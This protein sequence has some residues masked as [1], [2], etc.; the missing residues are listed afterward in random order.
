MREVIAKRLRSLHSLY[1][2]VPALRPGT[3]GAYALALLAVG[4]ATV[5][6]L[7]LD[8]YL[9]GVQFI[10]YSPAI[11]LITLISGFGPGLFCAVLSTAA[12]DFFLLSPRWTFSVE[13][14]GTLADL[15]AFGPVAAYLVLIIG[16][17]RFA[18]E[19][20][21]IEASKD[22]LQLALDAA[23]LGWWRYDVLAQVGSG[24][25]R[26][27][28]IFDVAADVLTIEDLKKLVHPDDAERFWADREAA[29]H[30]SAPQRPTHQYRVQ[31]RDAEVRWVEVQRLVHFEGAGHR[32][33]AVSIVGTV[34]DITERKE[35]EERLRLLMREVNH[36][37]RNMLSVVDAIAHQTVA[38][39]P[40]DYVGRFSERIR[41]LAAYQDLLVRSEW[42]GVEIEDL[43][44]AQLSDFA[45]LIG[46]RIALQGPRLRLNP[47]SA[48]AVGLALHELATNAVKYGALSTDKGRVDV[49]WETE[50]DTFTMS[51]TE[52]EGPPVFARERRGF[53][54][55]VMKE[56][57]E[58][59]LEGKVALDHAPSGA[60]WRLTCPSTNALEHW[61][62]AESPPSAHPR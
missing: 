6:R 11:I 41:A 1:I 60:T 51:W 50:G 3:V 26:F 32:R 24:D 35:Q 56:M 4:V 31:R 2:D 8:P 46:S 25:R 54:T 42:K 15:L 9:E 61:Q 34:Q 29:L 45:G 55:M 58:R 40:E 43:V 7:A 17:M 36:R 10:T 44:R 19:R 33:R 18:I 62:R 39:S 48:Q 12:A 57:A 5:L 37:A 13:D 23:Q 28:E 52:R 59:S 38:D 20:E 53:G 49:G 30:P 47:A 14:P 22:R 27:R 16:R 21:Q